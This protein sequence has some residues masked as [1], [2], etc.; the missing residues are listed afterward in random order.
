MGGDARDFSLALLRE[1]PFTVLTRW[2]PVL[3][4]GRFY[5]FV[6]VENRDLG[7]R[8]VEEGLARIHT[9]GESRPGGATVAAQKRRLQS[10]EQDARRSNRG[11]V[12]ETVDGGLPSKPRRLTESKVWTENGPPRA[13]LPSQILHG[14]AFGGNRMKLDLKGESNSIQI[15]LWGCNTITISTDRMHYVFA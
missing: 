9:K 5:A 4:S 3:D 11:G 14:A 13:D 7:E 2:E 10:V 8:L 12:G 15:L 1:G 6:T